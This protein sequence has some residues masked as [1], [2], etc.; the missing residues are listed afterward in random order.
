MRLAGWRAAVSLAALALFAPGFAAA[1]PVKPDAAT[2]ST[3]TSETDSTQ[4]ANDKPAG[5]A[6][7][8]GADIAEAGDKWKDFLADWSPAPVSASSMLGLSGES[9]TT[10]DNKRNLTVALQGLLSNDPANALGIAITPARTS[11]A[12]MGLADY[13]DDGASGVFARFLGNLTLSYAQGPITLEEVDYKRKAYAI[14]TNFYFDRLDDPA[15][16]YAEAFKKL[17][18]WPFEPVKPEGPLGPLDTSGPEDPGPKRLE[19][20]AAPADVSARMDKCRD[21]AEKDVNERWNRSQMSIA[22]GEARIRPKDDSRPEESLGKTLSVTMVY[23]FD[24]PR[25]APKQGE[26]R[27]EPKLGSLNKNYALTVNYRRSTDEPVLATLTQ[28]QTTFKDSSLFIARLTGGTAHSRIYI[29]VSDAKS[30]EITASQRAFKQ[31]L[32]LDY[33]IM[34]GTWLNLRVGKQRTVDGTDDETGT[35]FSVSYSPEAL[36]KH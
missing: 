5:D 7:P 35:L 25:T 34:K 20:K 16:A 11:L 18:C 29:E 28:P 30:H 8:E 15:I 12:P 33:R 31:A 27:G 6:K 4:P 14:D 2:P 9:I 26:P 13:A 23:G 24:F 10:I 21:A 36:L 3:T 19:G 1:D 22:Y 32:G 17:E